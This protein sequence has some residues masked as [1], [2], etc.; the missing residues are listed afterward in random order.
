M[1]TIEQYERNT[2]ADYYDAQEAEEALAAQLDERAG[3]IIAQMRSAYREGRAIK[4]RVTPGQTLSVTTELVRYAETES[5]E[6]GEWLWRALSG[7]RSPAEIIQSLISEYAHY[8][9]DAETGEAA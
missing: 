3:E 5:A 4:S 6:V 2:A 7:V 9:A 8:Y 1:A